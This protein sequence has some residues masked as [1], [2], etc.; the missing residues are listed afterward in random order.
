MPQATATG[1]IPELIVGNF[2]HGEAIQQALQMMG[3]RLAEGME[4]GTRSTLVLIVERED[5]NA[6]MVVAQDG[7][8]ISEPLKFRI[9]ATEVAHKGQKFAAAMAR[10]L[11][12][13]EQ[14]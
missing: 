2:H 13:R 14:T 8:N 9:I 6:V 11:E 12:R 5:G 1:S 3:L 10:R 4:Q 7:K